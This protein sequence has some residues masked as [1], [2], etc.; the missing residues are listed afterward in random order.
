MNLNIVRE[1]MRTL[2][3]DVAVLDVGGGSSPFPRADYILDA[4]PYP[5]ENAGSF[6]QRRRPLTDVPV[7]YGPDTWIEWDVCDRR[8]WPF[9][10]GQFDF[11]VCSHL[12]EDVRDPVWVCSELCRV[13]IAGYIETPSR[14]LEQSL[15]VE[16]PLYCGYCH[17]RWLVTPTADGL[18]LEFRYKPH[19]LHSLGAAHVCHLRPGYR[20]HPRLENLSLHW[21]GSLSCREVLEFDQDRVEAELIAFAQAARKTGDL[22]V[23]NGMP[24]LDRLR[25][26]VYDW[27]RCYGRR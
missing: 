19:S 5:D 7:R 18:G 25:R 22:V 3:P 4:R 11:A 12:L 16:H 14:A 2:P 8:P 10:D 23:R 1:L 15:G 20:L 24:F 21:R 9:R 27:R 13:A 26:N 6:R 17:H